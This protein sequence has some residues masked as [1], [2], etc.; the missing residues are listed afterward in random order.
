V[1]KDFKDIEGILNVRMMEDISK[2]DL[3][4]KV[5]ITKEGTVEDVFKWAKTVVEKDFAAILFNKGINGNALFALSLRDIEA[6]ESKLLS[7]GFSESSTIILAQEIKELH[8]APT[9]TIKA[10]EIVRESISSL[11][12][13]VNGLE[14][15][16][17]MLTPRRSLEDTQ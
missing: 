2:D 8:K 7:Y 12:D 13:F 3:G 4:E 1:D 9:D 14:F 15:L 6:I 10:A 5:V 16:N 11:I 17:A